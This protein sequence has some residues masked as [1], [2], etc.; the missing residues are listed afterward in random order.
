M[1]RTQAIARIARGLGFRQSL[2]P[3][4][5]IDVLKEAQRDLESGK[6]LPRFLVREDQTLT[7][8]SG[9]HSVALPA[10]FIRLDD[11]VLPYFTPAN[12]DIPRFLKSVSFVDGVVSQFSQATTVEAPSIF[13]V[14]ADTLDF[15]TTADVSYTLTWNYFAKA[16]VLDTDVENLWLKFAPD[17]LIA[18][19]GKRLARDFR[20]AEALNSF[21][22]M[23]QEARAAVFGETLAQETSGG[24]IQMGA[25]L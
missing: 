17:W 6:S 15:I 25:N 13:V 11:E 18:E 23:L 22:A 3:T 1:T 7:L 10:D 14:R 24:S 2:D 8:V 4:I 20:D 21:S 5:V 9:T 16:E 19:A 12:S